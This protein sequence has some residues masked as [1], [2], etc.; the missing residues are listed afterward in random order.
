MPLPNLYMNRIGTF[1]KEF[2]TLRIVMVCILCLVVSGVVYPRFS[3]L[4]TDSTFYVLIAESIARGEGL[5]VFGEAHTVF[6]PLPSIAIAL[7]FFV[8]GDGERAAHMLMLVT[9]ILS[10]PL[11]YWALTPCM[12]KRAAEYA[13]I[14]FGVT[15][16]WMW[17]YMTDINAQTLAAVSSIMLL[18]FLT[19]F[20]RAEVENV[21]STKLSLVLGVCV[22]ILYLERPE[23]ILFTVC[24]GGLIFWEQRN[25]MRSMQI[26]IQS[27]ALFCIGFLIFAAPYLVFLKNTLGEWTISGRVHEMVLIAT[28]NSYE[29]VDT[30]SEKGASI[31]SPP[32]LEEGVLTSIFD[33]VGGLIK[34]LLDGLLTSEHNLV[35]IYGF[36]GLFLFSL[37]VWSL[38]VRGEYWALGVSCILLTPVSAIALF[39]GGSPNYLVQ[40]LHLFALFIG[41]GFYVWTEHIQNL[42]LSVLCKKIYVV[43]G[44][45]VVVTYLFMSVVQRY[46]FL[47][48]DYTTPEVREMG[49]WIRNN[50]SDPGVLIARK[51]EVAYYAHTEWMLFPDVTSLEALANLMAKQNM[52]YVVVDRHART[53]RPEIY[54]R[55]LEESPVGFT[56]VHA[57]TL[58]G[59]TAYLYE[60]SE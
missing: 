31:V 6:S 1:F 46:V 51:P 52:T 55:I 2:F 50:V 33:N 9:G 54:T 22:A 44:L 58:H 60:R 26:R 17:S 41:Y 21:S 45:F 35:Q 16:T 23:Y 36:L 53:A 3:F 40:Y 24:I 57:I 15:G 19:R 27:L 43:V 56:L 13:A 18:G 4:G 32:I 30:D 38:Y 25:R 49:L 29:S 5:T 48:P 34:R 28:T 10:T 12:P 11:L 20:R 37:G 14:F 59:E 39:Q 7:F 42:S 8:F 47:P